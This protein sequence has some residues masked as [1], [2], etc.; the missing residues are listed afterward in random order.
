MKELAFGV[1]G[2]PSIDIGL[3]STGT[4]AQA[5]LGSL[6][7]QILVVVFVISSVL[8]MFWGV[9]GV[10]QYIFSGGDKQALEKARKRI[11][12]AI[13]GF[14]IVV[15]AF[16]ISQF[17]HDIFPPQPQGVQNVRTPT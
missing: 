3:P 15:A 5:T 17:V 4:L 6:V 13:V 12:W 14:I 10:F 11:T 7:S 9:W 8:L 16:L 2:Y 1:P